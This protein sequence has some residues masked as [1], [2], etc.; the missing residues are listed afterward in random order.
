MASSTA[1]FTYRGAVM[2]RREWVD[3]DDWS[4][5]MAPASR[6]AAVVMICSFVDSILVRGFN[7]YNFA[8]Q[9]PF[10]F[11]LVFDKLIVGL[12][13]DE[14]SVAGYRYALLKVVA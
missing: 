10:R 11:L 8:V 5:L 7:V 13:D 9:I 12:G 14:G 4:P 6:I 2:V 1:S 3:D